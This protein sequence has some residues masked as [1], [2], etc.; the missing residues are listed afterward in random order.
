MKRLTFEQ[1]LNEIDTLLIADTGLDHNDFPDC[2]YAIWYED[3]VSV[4]TAARKVIRNAGE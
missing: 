1:W 2:N 3:G 4:R